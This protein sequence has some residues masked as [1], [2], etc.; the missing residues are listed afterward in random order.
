MD[1]IAGNGPV[2]V[3]LAYRLSTVEL[4]RFVLSFATLFALLAMLASRRVWG[5][6][7]RRVLGVTGD[8]EP[9]WVLLPRQRKAF[10][11]AEHRRPPEPRTKAEL[12]PVQDEPVS[13]HSG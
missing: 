4:A 9:A 13:D 7:R 6:L 11:P 3:A 8:L 1:P 5:Y 10:Q 2:T 12:L